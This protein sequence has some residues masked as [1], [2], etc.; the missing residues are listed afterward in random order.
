MNKVNWF[1]HTPES[2]MDNA[3]LSGE[4]RMDDGKGTYMMWLKG[5]QM[6]VMT[7]DTLYSVW[8]ET[9]IDGGCHLV[10]CSLHSVL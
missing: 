5:A 7:A 9:S 8:G 1:I 2:Q 10:R 6:V 4:S 3:G